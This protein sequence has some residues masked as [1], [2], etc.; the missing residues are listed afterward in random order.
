[1]STSISRQKRRIMAR[2]AEA[3]DHAVEAD[4]RF[5]Q[6]HPERNYLIRVLSRAERAQIEA[7][8]GS[9]L[10]LTSDA[11]VAFSAIK[12]LAPGVRLRFV[13]FGP[14]EAVGEN[15]SEVEARAVWEGLADV[16]PTVREREVMLKQAMC[17]PGGPLHQGGA[18]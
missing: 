9:T 8:K 17:Q 3:A 10:N 7:L 13:A 11:P 6:R 5:F 16:H 15:L 1:M 12:Q 14:V 4:R 18:A 2:Y